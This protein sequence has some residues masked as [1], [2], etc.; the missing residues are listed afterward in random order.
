MQFNLTI[1][2][3]TGHDRK[4]TSHALNKS[5]S[6]NH[7]NLYL[8]EGYDHKQNKHT[9]L[10]IFFVFQFSVLILKLS[11]EF[12]LLQYLSKQFKFG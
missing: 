8:S 1:L 10:T 6:A 12:E 3:E 5:E 11:T 9:Q 2:G 7:A 4:N